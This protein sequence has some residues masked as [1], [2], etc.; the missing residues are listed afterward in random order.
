MFTRVTSCDGVWLHQNWCHYTEKDFWQLLSTL[1]ADICS[2][3][4]VMTAGS[5]VC[6]SSESPLH[7]TFTLFPPP[8]PLHTH[9]WLHADGGKYEPQARTVSTSSSSVSQVNFL[10]FLPI[11]TFTN[12]FP[13]SQCLWTDIF[14]ISESHPTQALMS[15]CWLNH[16]QFPCEIHFTAVMCEVIKKKHLYLVCL[17]FPRNESLMTPSL[18]GN[19]AMKRFCL[20]ERRAQASMFNG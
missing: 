20:S 2:C 18:W 6:E 3:W 5:S 12:N 1:A 16:L 17:L 9:F 4:G 8:H 10:V 15:Q 13:H 19:E 14:R 7:G 11:Y